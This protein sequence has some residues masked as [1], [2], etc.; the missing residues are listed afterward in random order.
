MKSLWVASM[1]CVLEGDEK[2]PLAQYG[3]SHTARMKTVYR[4]GLGNRYG[5]VMQTIAGIHYNVSFPDTLWEILQEQDGDSRQPE[6]FQ[7]PTLF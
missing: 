2:I 4:E 5:R 3:S 6:G 1:P 7:D